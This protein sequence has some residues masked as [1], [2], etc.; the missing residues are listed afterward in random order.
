M[1]TNEHFMKIALE[2]AYI[3]QDLGEV[4]VGAVIVDKRGQV[5]GKG[6]NQKESGADPTLHAEMSAIKEAAKNLGRWRLNDCT[7]Y[8]TLEPCPMCAGAIVQ[9]RVDHVVIGAL[10]FKGGGVCSKF[11][12]GHNDLL[13][14]QFQ[15]TQ[16]V[17]EG[18]CSQVLSAFFKKLRKRS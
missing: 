9:A 11:H 2:Q 12:I 16:G 13:N 1:S 14:H 5:I 10:D 6:H 4:P 8:T 18:E 7:L 15:L 3:A 17:L